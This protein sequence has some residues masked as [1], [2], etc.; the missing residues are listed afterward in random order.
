MGKEVGGVPSFAHHGFLTRSAHWPVLLTR[1]W[2]ALLVRP[3][4][5]HTTLLVLFFLTKVAG[6]SNKKF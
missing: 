1:D 2:H 3:K 6:N 5:T 4:Y